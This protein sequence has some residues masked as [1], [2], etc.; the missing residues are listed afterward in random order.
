MSD[1]D[2]PIH[3]GKL[4]P[5]PQKKRASL[6]AEGPPRSAASV[7]G[8]A[9]L[10]WHRKGWYAHKLTFKKFVNTLLAGGEMF[11]RRK[12][13]LCLP[14]AVKI[15]I[16]PRCNLKCTVC[17]HAHA[18]GNPILARQRFSK[19]QDMPLEKFQQIIDQVRGRSSVANVYYLGDPLLH[20]DYV[21]MCRYA[22]DAG[23]C[24]Q[25]SSNFSYR[26]SDEQIDGLVAS[27]VTH[28]R[29]CIDGLR[30]E[31]YQRTRVGGQIQLV[32]SNLKRL[33]A[34]KKKAGRPFPVVE[35]QYIKYQHNVHELQPARVLFE[36]LGANT[37]TS[38]WGNLGNWIDG[39]PGNY[40]VFG[41][42]RRRWYLPRCIWPYS[43]MLIKHN[44]DVLPCCNYRYGEQYAE[45]V[46]ARTLGNVFETSVREVWNSPAYQELRRF[47]LNPRLIEKRPELKE[48]FCY[49]CWN[50]FHTDYLELRGNRHVFDQVYTIN[51]RGIPV[52]QVEP[53]KV[54]PHSGWWE[55]T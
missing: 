27:G 30:Q 46:R 29:I 23:L 4:P 39:D 19:R 7:R 32:M 5:R 13:L 41:P 2:K 49:C 44:G 9:R 17:V 18:N 8:I 6:I 51:D 31:T 53:E 42:K 40:R 47:V 3:Q 28:L 12:K 38:F 34:A 22:A 1:Q 52:R 33:T 11:L 43:A 48:T 36:K 25:C 45:G 35:V 16:T 10:T 15:D 54:A 24:I 55:Y 26:L 20:P 21:E 14:M 50:L 37:F